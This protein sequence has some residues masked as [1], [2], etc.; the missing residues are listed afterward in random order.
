MPSAAG[1]H[2]TPSARGRELTVDRRGFLRTSLGASAGLLAAPTAVS[3]LAAADAKAATAPPLAFVDDY[4]TNIVANATAETNAVIRALG[5]F[6]KVWKTGDAWN[7]GTPL[8][9]E[10]LRAN[11]RYSIRLTHGRTEEQAREAF[12]YDR[13]HQ[14]YAIIGGLGPLADLYR[15]GAKAVTSITSAPHGIP[16]AKINDAVPA[17]APAGS[18]LG[19]GSYDSDLGQ[20]AKLVDTVRGDFTSSNPAKFS[21]QYPRPWRMNENSEVVETGT[22]DALGFPVYDSDV[23]VVTQ[24]LRQRSDVPAEDGGFPSGHTNAFHLAALAYAYAVP[25]RFQEIVTRAFELSHTRI[26]SGMHSTVDV[27]GGR[28]M[29]TALAAAVLYKPE[30]TALK[31]AARKQAAEYFQARTGTTADTLF[32]YAHSDAH[33][34]YRDRAA[35][36]ALVTPKLTYVLPRQGRSTPLTVP[37]GAEVLLETRLPYLSADQRRAVLRTTALPSGYV[38]LDGFEQW[39]RLNLAVAADGYGS[40][41]SDVTVELDAA[42]HGFGAAD[43]WRNDIDGRGGLTKTGTGTL[44]LTGQNSYTGGT[45]LKAGVLVSASSHALGHGDVRVQGGTLRVTEPVQLHGT[46]S[47]QSGTLAVTLRK[48]RHKEVVTVGRRVLLE[49]GSVLSL[50]LDAKNPPAVG[51]VV[52]VIGGAALRGHFDRVV[53]NSDKIRAVPVYTAKGLSVRLLKR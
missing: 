51:S 27:I 17:D 4:S 19:A 43:A 40:F 31:A 18:A 9:P 6:A 29:A 42:A 34:K 45:D 35:N 14:S 30:N 32:A 11:V 15:S 26:M 12:V 21:F 39:G 22:T 38:M 7:T 50:T 5:G 46:Y 20:V 16:A 24:L 47:Q 48:D 33:D 53:V 37:K 2:A 41:E 44:T 10:I 49:K 13:Q 25:E 1:H 23:V 3:W 8:L 52:P 36:L 28:I